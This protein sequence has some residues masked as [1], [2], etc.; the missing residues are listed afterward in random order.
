MYNARTKG[1]TV[2]DDCGAVEA[3]GVRPALSRGSHENI[4]IT[5]PLDLKLAE[6]ILEARRGL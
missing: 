5:R 4:K 2:T 1:L 6:L 3:L